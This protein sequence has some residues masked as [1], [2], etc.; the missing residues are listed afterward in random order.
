VVAEAYTSICNETIA[1]GDFELMEAQ[2]FSNTPCDAGLWPQAIDEEISR[3]LARFCAEGPLV[4][5]QTCAD[6][7]AV[8]SPC[9][10]SSASDPLSNEASCQLVCLSNPDF[11]PG[12]WACS[13]D[14]NNC[15]EAV[16]CLWATPTP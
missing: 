7:C 4:D 11:A 10:P 13:A 14:A 2:T 6:G 8:F 12:L 5:P 3:W 9:L 16:E 15:A 1:D